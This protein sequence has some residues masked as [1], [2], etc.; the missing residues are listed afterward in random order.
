M[1]AEMNRLGEAPTTRHIHL[2][3]HAVDQKLLRDRGLFH[4][5]WGKISLVCE[6]RQREPS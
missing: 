3:T 6:Y 4:A 1:V 2:W 5:R